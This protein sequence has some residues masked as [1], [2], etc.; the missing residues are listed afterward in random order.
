VLV[1]FTLKPNGA[2]TDI[3]IARS[4]HNIFNSAATS[5]V[6]QLVCTGQSE[7]VKVRV[8]FVFKLER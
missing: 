7:P 5:A 6:S 3:T 8:P 4:T 2:I 1:E